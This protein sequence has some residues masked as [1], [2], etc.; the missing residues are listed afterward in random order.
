MRQA[1]NNLSKTSG[2]GQKGAVA[3]ELALVLPLFALLLLGTFEMGLIS[4]E[5]QVL[6][7]AAREGARFS[8][9]PANRMDLAAEPS[10]VLL[11]I[12]NRVV[13]YLANENM[14]VL[15]A[16]VTVD[17]EYP[18]TIGGLTVNG[19]NITINYQRALALPGVTSFLSL[20]AVE[21][22]GN[23]VFRNFY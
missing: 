20:G 8:A 15:P 12:Q 9:L 23:A 1:I 7:N 21:L 17:Q 19:S 4:Q 22:T 10:D 6:Q 16:D 3:V 11:A 2:C 18:I 5:H 13:A 14:T